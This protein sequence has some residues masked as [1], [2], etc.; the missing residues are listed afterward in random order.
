MTAIA[1][2]VE[3][4]RVEG[5]RVAGYRP[6]LDG[7][8][9][10]AVYLVVVFHSGS[11]SFTGGYVGVDVFFVLSGFLVTQLLLRDLEGGGSISLARF[12]SRRFRRLLPAA[13]VVLVVT[14][15]VYS[16]LASPI[17]VTQSVDGFRASFLYYANWEFIAQSSDY[18][19]ADINANPVLQFWSLAVEE[20]FYLLWPLLLGG[21]F[22]ISV[23]FRSR[24]WLM[25]RVVVL[26]GAVASLLWALSLRTA[27][28]NRAYYGTDARAYQLLAGAL[29]ALTPG[30][31]TS[32]AG[33]TRTARVVAATSIAALVVVASSWVQLNAIERG[34]AATI[35]T[36]A[37]LITLEIAQGGLAQRTL[38]LAPVVYLGKISYGTYLW[39]W[40]VILVMART[41]NLSPLSTVALTV[42]I[43]TGL[44]S[45]SYQILEYPVRVS[46]LLDR[47]R[48]PVIASGLAISAVS[49]L[50]VV[51][52][53]LET[54]VPSSEGTVVA[55][56]RGGTPVPDGVEA[57]YADYFNF[58]R[59]SPG[60][61]VSCVLVE[62]EGPKVLIVGDSHA[63]MLT[64]MLSGIAERHGAELSVGFLSYCPWTKGIRYAG[65]GRTCFAEQQTMFEETIPELDPDIVVLVHRSY[66]DPANRLDVADVDAGRLELGS[67]EATAAMRKRITDVVDGLRADGRLVVMIEP[68]PVA[69]RD[70]N[71]V[72]CLSGAEFVESCRFVTQ[73][74]PTPEEQ[75]MREV[76]KEDAGV[77]SL[78]LDSLVCPYKPI[79]D[80]VV[81]GRV[82]RS[83]DNHLTTTFA[84]AVLSD[85]VDEFLVNNGVLAAN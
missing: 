65:I 85:A 35:I 12:Y 55:E 28:P 6:F 13:F 62:G 29:L 41:S 77:W 4:S 25:I 67:D 76:A 79:C 78:D 23:R 42:L 56:V 53:I 82:V 17:E 8:R 16:A 39:H 74:E 5:S 49:G 43:A 24:Q 69:P 63:G 11:E 47:Y 37:L 57:A 71:P 45:L 9:A 48:I 19:G 2:D 7:L 10:V 20:Q 75:I 52:R 38:S 68:V 34:V 54:A 40:P 15:L 27:N 30:L 14:A 22:A 83:D 73:T 1:S 51:P 21:L 50:L 81:L 36:V 80:P 72:T 46:T 3:G 26:G 33:F 66:D 32:L 18:F 60:R 61:G 84:T 70:Q 44:A 64:P 59:C 58:N 31:I